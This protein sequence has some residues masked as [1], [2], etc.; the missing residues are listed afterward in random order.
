MSDIKSFTA[1][2]TLQSK[3]LKYVLFTPE[4]CPIFTCIS[5]QKHAFQNT[6]WDSLYS[7]ASAA[8]G[9]QPPNSSL[10][11]LDF[12]TMFNICDINCT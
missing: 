1:E 2:K 3:L 6:V 7:I 5:E 10:S 8:K 11:E 9:I 4:I 12:T